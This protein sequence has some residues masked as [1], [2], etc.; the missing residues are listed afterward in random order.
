MQC[1]AEAAL[2]DAASLFASR[3]IKNLIMRRSQSDIVHLPCALPWTREFRTGVPLSGDRRFESISSSGE[4]VSAVKS[5]AVGEDPV[6]QRPG[7]TSSS[8]SRIAVMS[9]SAAPGSDRRV[10]PQINCPAAQHRGVQIEDRSGTAF[11][12]RDRGSCL[13]RPY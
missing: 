7:R 1:L 5:R 6:D 11:R 12:S 2:I 4:S 8:P 3:R 13:P 9:T 10:S